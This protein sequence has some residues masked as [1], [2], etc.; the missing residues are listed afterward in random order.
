MTAVREA[1]SVATADVARSDR[2]YELDWLRALVVFCVVAYHVVGIFAAG[3]TLYLHGGGQGLQLDVASVF[4]NAW[5]IPLLFAISGA[6]ALFSLRHRSAWSYLSRRVAR[7]AVPFLLGTLVLIPLQVYGV[8]LADPSLL[9]ASPVPISNPHLLNSYPQ[10]YAQYLLA[11]LY[12]LGHYSPQLEFVFW[13]HLW[14]I[15]RLIVCAVVTLPV[16]VL[17]NTG[18][19]KRF[20]DLITRGLRW[21]PALLVPGPLLGGVIAVL[22]GPWA[23]PPLDTWSNLDWA[24][25]GVLVLCYLIGY[26][27][28]AD[29]R[30]VR[31]I[32]R[33]GP[34]ALALGLISFGMLIGVSWDRLPMPYG[35][36]L[37]RVTEGTV[38]W[39]WVVVFLGLGMRFLAR[40]S[41]ALAFLNEGTYSFYVLHMPV[42]VGVAGL[43][44]PLAAPLAVEISLL[45]AGTLLA[46]LAVYVLVVRP[47]AF[48]RFLLG[49]QLAPSARALRSVSAASG[50]LPE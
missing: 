13:G 14:F 22:R 33:A 43:V 47:F 31:A 44:L 6:S 16:L 50:G 46:T 40:G 7:L 3:T 41:R 2:R 49:V 38:D 28:Y 15:A 21:P 32:E 10:F 48:T 39:L 17:F 24:Q 23:H 20:I 18:P 9:R 25:F 30:S 12:F 36:V 4:L 26:V 34:L 8:L 45:L 1:Q 11:Y 27:L 5:A 29:H 42:L 19:G 35:L 37:R